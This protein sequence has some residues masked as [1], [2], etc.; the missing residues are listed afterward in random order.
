MAFSMLAAMAM[1]GA[2]SS[3][4]RT[5]D[6]HERPVAMRR[7]MR[8]VQVRQRAVDPLEDDVLVTAEGFC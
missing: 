7:T 4:I 5:E 8:I 1:A 3:P 6:V 2:Y